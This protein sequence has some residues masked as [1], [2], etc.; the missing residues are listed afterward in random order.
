M[1]ASTWGMFKI[2]SETGRE[3]FT[4]EMEATTKEIGEIT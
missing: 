1:V 3:L 2:K 4:I